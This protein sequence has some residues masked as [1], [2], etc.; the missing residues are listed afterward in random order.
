MS[1]QKLTMNELD[2]KNVNE[3]KENNPEWKDRMMQ[4][5]LGVRR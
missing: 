5:F 2:M 3:E 4:T 1:K